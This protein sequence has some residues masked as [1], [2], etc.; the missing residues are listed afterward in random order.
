MRLAASFIW[1]NARA[2]SATRGTSSRNMTP[3][4]DRDAQRLGG[5][6]LV[7]QVLQREQRPRRC[8]PAPTRSGRWARAGSPPPRRRRA[9]ACR[10]SRAG[11]RLRTVRPI[12]TSSSAHSRS[13]ASARSASRVDVGGALN[14][15]AACARDARPRRCANVSICARDAGAVAI[16]E[17]QA[18]RRARRTRPACRAAR[19]CQGRALRARPNQRSGLPRRACSPARARRR[20]PG[21][22]AAASRST[23]C[24]DRAAAASAARHP[25]ARV[26]SG[27]GGGG[28]GLAQ[29]V[30]SD[31]R[32]VGMRDHVHRRP[33]SSASSH[34][35]RSADDRPAPRAARG[36]R[37]P[38]SIAR[39]GV[40]L[41][42]AQ[43]RLDAL[44]PAAASRRLRSPRV[45]RR[46]AAPAS[47]VDD[48][49]DDQQDAGDDEAELERDC[50]SGD[51]IRA[52]DLES[53]SA[54]RL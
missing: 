43:R 28:R 4:V 1:S 41:V 47:V 53:A 25:R 39:I 2:G 16:G 45:A 13:S 34:R 17:Q 12:C 35:R 23:R 19:R 18:A 14:A 42:R 26:R 46:R 29:R 9:A 7:A 32:H 21:A 6:R 49:A 24:R 50:T 3:C 5:E 40:V 44:P 52:G 54:L 10:R 15:P 22:P 27:L 37:A 38:P 33:R 36:G 31:Q 20:R 8:P 11:R 30:R 48:D 51:V